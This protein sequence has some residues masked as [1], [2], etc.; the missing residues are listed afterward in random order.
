[1]KVMRRREFLRIVQGTAIGSLFLSPGVR[2]VP[3]ASSA[4]RSGLRDTLL[5]EQATQTVDHPLITMV[6]VEL[7]PGGSAAP[8]R[9]SGPVFGYL[10]EGEVVIQMENQ[11]PVTYRRGQAWY[12]PSGLVHKVTKNPSTKN[13]SL[14]L[15]VVIG[16]PGEPA[17]SPV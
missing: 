2:Q 6:R 15:A 5:L 3:A 8:H 4:P 10:L 17:K 7:P 16:E 9:H 13:R 11:E 14:F 1:M 12:E